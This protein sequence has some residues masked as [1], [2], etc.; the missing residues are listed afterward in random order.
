MKFFSKYLT[1][2][3]LLGSV[4]LTS[5]ST[6]AYA[7]FD[8]LP[9]TDEA[10]ISTD[11]LE[12]L[13]HLSILLVYGNKIEKSIKEAGYEKEYIETLDSAVNQLSSYLSYYNISKDEFSSIF[14]DTAEETI[15]ETYTDFTQED[16]TESIPDLILQLGV[17]RDLIPLPQTGI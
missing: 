17:V 6:A 14:L 15:K 1:V 10:E 8:A 3:A 13:G 7:D 2:A 9:Y 12:R 16:I 5:L 4:A 11:Q